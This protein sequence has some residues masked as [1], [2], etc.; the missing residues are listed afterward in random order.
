MAKYNL[1]PLSTIDDT[2]AHGLLPQRNQKGVYY[3]DSSC[4]ANLSQFQLSS[5]NRRILRKTDSFT[6]QLLPLDQFD[7]NPKVK[8]QCLDWAQVQSWD[9]PSSSIK[10]IF[11]NHIFTHV[12]RW[13]EKDLPI[14][15]AIC[16]FS[17]QVSHIA[18]VF[19]HPDFGRNSLPI[20][21]VLQA[22]IDSHQLGLKYCYL[23]RFSPPLGFY[24]RTMPGFE[25]YHQNQWLT[26]PQWLNQ[27]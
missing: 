6:Y 3:S 19:Y 5:E 11:T 4:R 15:Y 10:S 16:Y 8:K 23:G 14:A 26:Y 25:I 18:Y 2:Y 21:L 13:Q 7:F 17:A 1:Q 24:K 20:R 9:F 27:S 12:Y 22:I